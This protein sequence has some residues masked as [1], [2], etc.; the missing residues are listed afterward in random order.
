MT[1]TSSFTFDTNLLVYS[2][3]NSDRAKQT[4]SNRIIT[5]VISSGQPILLQCLSEFYA[6]TTK[7]RRL[8]TDDAA[9]VVRKFLM[10]PQIIA[11][12]VRDVDEAVSMQTRYQIQ[13]F[14]ALLL[15]TAARSGCAILFSEDLQHDG[16]YGSITVRN[17]FLLSSAE[18]DALFR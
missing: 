4:V 13:F 3:D 11:A 5:A 6:V 16:L 8:S 2:A 9:L 10:L 17:P 18:L 1:A 12:G 15:A 14:D 7:K